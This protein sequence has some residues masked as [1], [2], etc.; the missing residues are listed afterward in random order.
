MVQRGRRAVYEPAARSRSRSR[1]RSN[2]TRVPAQGADVRA[3]LADRAARAD[4]RGS[5]AALHAADRLA[6]PPALRD[7]ACC[8]SSCSRPRS[9]SSATAGSTTVVLAAQLALLAAAAAGVGIA[10]YYV[11]VTWATV[12][13][14]VELPAPRRARDVGAG[15]GHALRRPESCLDV[16]IAGAGLAVTSPLLAAAALAVKL[17]D[18]GPV[19]YRQ[20]RVGQGR[21]RLRAAE[22]AD[23]GRRRRDDRR[24]VTPSTAATRASRASAASCAGSRSTSCRSSGTSSAA[25][26]R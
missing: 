18:G 16:A 13:S 15:G 21:R 8:T 3:L 14:L 1:R 19:L 25:T 2:E 6:P 20:T 5:S 4:A 11:L 22:A 7:R 24:R 10:R 9:R 17:E 26:C 12:V 23:D